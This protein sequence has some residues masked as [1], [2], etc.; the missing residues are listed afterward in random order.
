MIEKSRSEYR[1][2]NKGTFSKVV[3]ERSDRIIS[4]AC[5]RLM[6]RLVRIFFTSAT[7]SG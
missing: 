6:T 3:A 7:L 4:T 2:I 1:C 5:S